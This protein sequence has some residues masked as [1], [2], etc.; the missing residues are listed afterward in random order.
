MYYQ[1]IF[2]LFLI[3]IGTAFAAPSPHIGMINNDDVRDIGAVYSQAEFSSAPTFLLMD[4]QSPRC[5]PLYV[6]SS[7]LHRSH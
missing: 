4:K 7:L 3:V 6:I 5:F 2:S 1:H